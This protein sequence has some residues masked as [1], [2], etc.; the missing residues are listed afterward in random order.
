MSAY[1]ALAGRYDE[2]TRD[3]PYGRLADYCEAVFAADGGEFRL[4]LDLC[5]GTGSLTLELASRGYDM[6]GADASADMLMEAM[7]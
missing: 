7:K 6:I 3:I 1:G 4:L 2:L 5:C